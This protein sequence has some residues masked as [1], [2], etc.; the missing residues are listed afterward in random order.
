[1]TTVLAVDDS[2]SMRQ[3]LA[4]TLRQGGYEVIEAGDGAEALKRLESSHDVRVVVTDQNMP[5]LD[6][7]S[8]T[9][10]L[11][12]QERWAKVPV[13]IL[14]TESSP[15]IKREGRAAGATGWLMK[16]FEPQQLLDTL[17]MVLPQE[18]VARDGR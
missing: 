10:A 1:M 7:L 6:G 4:Y 18:E 9:R 8:L 13:L 14:T 15:E 5:H 11:R 2:A 17:A 16:P 3:M 12:A